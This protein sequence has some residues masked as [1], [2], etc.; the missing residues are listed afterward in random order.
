[1]RPV[2]GA[3][4]CAYTEIGTHRSF[5]GVDSVSSSTHASLFFGVQAVTNEEGEEVD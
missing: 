4:A 1:M 2:L 3:R 5:A